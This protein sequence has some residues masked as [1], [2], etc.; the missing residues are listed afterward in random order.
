M[1]GAKTGTFN[2]GGKALHD[3]FESPVAPRSEREFGK[4]PTQ[5][6]VELMAHFVRTLSN[7]GDVVL[8]PFMGSGSSGAAAARL[9]REF[10]GIEVDKGYFEIAAN[11]WES[12]AR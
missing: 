9:G 7:P 4:H 6:P 8:D 2:N 5:K 11:G 10:V 12:R 1:N 3:F